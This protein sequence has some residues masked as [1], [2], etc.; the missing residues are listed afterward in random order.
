MRSASTVAQ[1]YEV[2]QI[3]FGWDDE[4]LNR[5][6]IRSREYAVYHDGGGRIG[7][8]A[9]DVRLCDLKLRRLE[10]FVWEYDFWRQLDSRSRPRN[11]SPD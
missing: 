10:R 2:L 11:L 7:I 3:A 5:F 1:L 8:D 9:T 6:E 4:H